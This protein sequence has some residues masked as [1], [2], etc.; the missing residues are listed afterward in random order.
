M[1]ETGGRQ[2]L[3]LCLSL[4]PPAP[5]W[6]TESRGSPGRSEGSPDGLSRAHTNTRVHTHACAHSLS[7]S[8]V[9]CYP[10]CTVTKLPVTPGPCGGIRT[11][12]QHVHTRKH[13]HDSHA[14]RL[15]K[16]ATARA[17]A[18]TH[19]QQ[20]CSRCVIGGEDNC[21]LSCSLEWA[22]AS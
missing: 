13:A 5:Q 14:R 2:A 9:I 22:P 16:C 20:R 1:E 17:R 15:R 19:T 7:H 3:L 4:V 21:N 6:A 18:R 11:Q 12:I 8:H 10:I